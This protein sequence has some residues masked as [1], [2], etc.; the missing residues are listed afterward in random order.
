MNSNSSS[1]FVGLE[2]SVDA[3]NTNSETLATDDTMRNSG[4]ASA[5]LRS[6]ETTD[7]GPA[8][9]LAAID[10]SSRNFGNTSQLRQDTGNLKYALPATDLNKDPRQAAEVHE[11]MER[12]SGS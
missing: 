6:A 8:V 1:P 4:D 11:I 3:G 7:A 12:L 2:L 9:K 5:P 10:G